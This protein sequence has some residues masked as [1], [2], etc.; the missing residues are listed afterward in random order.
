MTAF[1]L[2]REPLSSL[3]LLRFI[4]EH[5]APAELLSAHKTDFTVLVNVNWSPAGFLIELE[6]ILRYSCVELATE[7]C[8]A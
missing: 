4:W 5:E 3:T 2:G 8:S 7:T 1:K 6:D